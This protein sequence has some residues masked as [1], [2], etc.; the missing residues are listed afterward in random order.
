MRARD[1]TN[2]WQMQAHGTA[3]T[4]AERRAFPR[5][6]MGFRKPISAPAMSGMVVKEFSIMTAAICRKRG[7]KGHPGQAPYSAFG[8]VYLPH[9]SAACSTAHHLLCSRLPC[10]CWLPQGELQ[11]HHQVS[12]QTERSLRCR[13]HRA[14]GHS[15][16]P[17]ASLFAGLA[18]TR[19]H[20][21]CYD[22]QP[23]II[24]IS[25]R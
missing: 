22:T 13:C 25:T 10:P 18:A 21:G 23:G 7:V 5:P 2:L 17:P 20:P 16:V 8:R 15:P 14:A 1:S 19:G 4:V 12:A 11:Q 6:T 9:A 3:Q 24:Y